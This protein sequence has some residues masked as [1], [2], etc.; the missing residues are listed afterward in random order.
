MIVSADNAFVA[1]AIELASSLSV[2]PPPP[3]P[4][5]GDTVRLPTLERQARLLPAVI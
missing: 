5:P 1:G 4:D 2:P 3:A